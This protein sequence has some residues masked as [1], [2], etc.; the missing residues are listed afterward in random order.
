MKSI[1]FKLGLCFLF[2]SGYSQGLTLNDL[3]AGDVKIIDYNLISEKRIS[4]TVFEYTYKVS[5]KNTSGVR[6]EGVTALFTNFEAKS[7][8]QEI[9][10]NFSIE[11]IQDFDKTFLTLGGLDINETKESLDAITIRYD[12]STA[13]LNISDIFIFISYSKEILI[14]DTKNNHFSLFV[15]PNFKVNSHPNVS[16]LLITPHQNPTN[17]N[18]IENLPFIT[19]QFIELQLPENKDFEETEIYIEVKYASEPYRLLLLSDNKVKWTAF[20]KD[21]T[22]GMAKFTLPIDEN[23]KVTFAL[24][25]EY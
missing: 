25:G 17:I 1:I 16:D 19:D 18:T 20:E 3:Y 4:N 8:E 21:T 23:R 6:L 7:P 5:I 24:I 2:I 15:S 9:D 10:F 12:R 11:G 14:D 13:P 22:Q